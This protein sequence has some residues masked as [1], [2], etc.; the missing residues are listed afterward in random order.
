MRTVT[1]NEEGLTADRPV[2]VLGAAFS[3]LGKPD[4]PTIPRGLPV[5]PYWL[6]GW[7]DY[8]LHNHEHYEIGIV[9]S[10]QG[11]HETAVGSSLITAGSVVVV[12]PGEVH[13][14]TH[15]DGVVIVNCAYLGEWLITDL[16]ELLSEGDLL[17]L[18]LHAAF[19]GA[20]S[21]P[22]VPQW[23]IDSATREACFR[24]LAD[25][26][27]EER[28]PK[29]SLIRMKSCLKKVM[30]LL[31]RSF[32]ASGGHMA[33]RATPWIRS[34][35]QTIEET[36]LQGEPFR[37]ASVAESLG[38]DAKTFSR[39]FHQQIGASPTRYYQHRRVQ[40]ACWLLLHSDKP[41]TDIA[42][43][44]GYTDSAHLTH[45]FKRERGCT[46]REYRHKYRVA[47]EPTPA[48]PMPMGSAKGDAP[49]S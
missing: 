42:H 34:T 32:S 13:G 23:Q 29:P 14:H 1:R 39:T 11:T 20:G 44:L 17:P 5:A 49:N 25:I 35:L 45:V 2:R 28:Q 36:V 18:F 41:V 8:E 16:H 22:F 43:L 24:E 30:V 48:S 15:M 6:Q 19:P 37:V 26:A 46:P 33:L 47:S 12:A 7:T 10:G 27:Y 3:P 38:L 4:P 31:D 21:R 9:C 40:R